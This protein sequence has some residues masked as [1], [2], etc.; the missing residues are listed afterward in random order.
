VSDNHLNLKNIRFFV[1]DEADQ[2]IEQSNVKSILGI[3]Q[4]IPK[5]E[6]PLQVLMF[7]ATLH[8]PEIKKMS[9]QICKFPQWIDLKGKPTVPENVDHAIIL[10]DPDQ[11]PVKDIKFR[12]Q[13][14]GIH[15]KEGQNS[16]SEAIK[17][18]KGEVIRKVIDKF[19]MD[20]ALIFVRTKVDGD[21][22][23]NY[24]RSLNTGMLDSYSTAVLHAGKSQE[25]RRK[26]LQDFKKG[27]VRFLIATD[28]AAR[29]IDIES[30]PFVINYTLPAKPEIYLHRIGRTGRADKIGLAVSLVGTQEEK[31][32]YHTCPSKGNNCNNTRLVD[33]GGCA[34]MYNE[35][36]ILKSIEDL[37]GSPVTRLGP[38]LEF[39][40]LRQYGEKKEGNIEL[41]KHQLQLKPVVEQLTILEEQAQASYLNFHLRFNKK[42]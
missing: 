34:I 30:L 3:F 41:I 9:E 11:T 29:G 17:I 6:K 2:M 7:S 10:V 18:L 5:T 20:Q 39:P 40:N 35:L 12:I 21:N 31:V 26:S 14:D 32:W 19:K 28:V 4:K 36:E 1:L 27:D 38:D 37:I 8:S 16:A 25:Q 13:T 15:G 42:K 23:H 24:F 33:Q 22:L